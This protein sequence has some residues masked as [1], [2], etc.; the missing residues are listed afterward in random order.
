MFALACFVAFLL[1]QQIPDGNY[2][3]RKICLDRIRTLRESRDFERAEVV[4]RLSKKL[5][6]N[7]T[8]ISA[9]LQKIQSE[10]EFW[11]DLSPKPGVQYEIVQMESGATVEIL[12]SAERR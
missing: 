12:L 5:F 4:A 9:V 6:P 1:P 7:D 3:L 10:R 2:E 8:K 11:R